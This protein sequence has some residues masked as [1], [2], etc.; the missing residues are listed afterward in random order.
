MVKFLVV[1][2]K[3]IEENDNSDTFW[4]TFKRKVMSHRK[5]KYSIQFY[6]DGAHDT[7]MALKCVS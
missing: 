4:S 5:E 1:L 2:K 7:G 6:H 3:S